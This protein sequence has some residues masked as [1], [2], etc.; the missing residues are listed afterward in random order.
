MEVHVQIEG[1][2]ETLD[3]GDGGRGGSADA[4]GA[5]T[6]ALP[7]EDRGGEGGERG[8]QEAAV[9]G[10]ARAQAPGQR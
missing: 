10:E 1:R 4:V 5:G 8:G 3:G 9:V 2:A 6:G 7:A